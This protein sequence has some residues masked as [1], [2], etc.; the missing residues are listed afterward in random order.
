MIKK[1]SC[2]GVAYM[3]TKIDGDMADTTIKCLKCGYGVGVR[4]SFDEESVANAIEYWNKMIEQRES[5]EN[6]EGH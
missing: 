1:C 2:G 4:N 6:N 5:E 3:E